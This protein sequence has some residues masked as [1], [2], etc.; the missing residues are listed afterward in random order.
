VRAVLCHAIQLRTPVTGRG[1][2]DSKQGRTPGPG[3]D[4]REMA[5]DIGLT[6]RVRPVVEDGVANE[7]DVACRGSVHA[8]GKRTA[9][10]SIRSPAPSLPICSSEHINCTL[11]Q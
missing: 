6:A 10:V 4:G 7:N 9:D 8:G 2:I 3:N 11:S 5:N 1:A